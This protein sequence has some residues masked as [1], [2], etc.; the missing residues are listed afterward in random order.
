MTCE[1]CGT[2]EHIGVCQCGR[3]VCGACF[4]L[5]ELH[6]CQPSRALQRLATQHE[7]GE[8]AAQ[9]DGGTLGYF[10]RKIKYHR[11]LA[12]DATTPGDRLFHHKQAA[13]WQNVLVECSACEQAKRKDD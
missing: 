7:I 3:H 12:E 2:G 5:H 9:P 13:H 8:T 11:M 10:I 4:A 6:D 1:E